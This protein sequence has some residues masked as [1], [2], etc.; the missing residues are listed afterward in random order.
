MGSEEEQKQ[1]LKEYMDTSFQSMKHI[2]RKRM[3]KLIF[4]ILVVLLVLFIIFHNPFTHVFVAKKDLRYYDIRLNNHK[5]SVS[6]EI[7]D[8]TIIPNLIVLPNGNSDTFSIQNKST[9][10]EKPYVLSLKSYTCFIPNKN[11][12][13]KTSCSKDIANKYENK[14]TSY[15]RMQILKYDY[16]PKYEYNISRNYLS[17]TYQINEN[18]WQT[19]PF[20]EYTIV[21]DGKFI[22]DI[23]YYVLKPN[24]YVIKVEVSYKFTKATLSFGFI[25]DGE[26]VHTL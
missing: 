3:L 4:I 9:I 22:E 13:L 14:D 19:R 23:T 7:Q 21:Y 16:N 15:T 11:K 17:R 5:L 18:T 8:T 2:K 20:E 1:A 6:E 26:N 25:N 24:V 12:R 10:E